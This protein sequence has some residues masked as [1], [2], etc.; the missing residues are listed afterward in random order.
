MDEPTIRFPVTCPDC[1]KEALF[2]RSL[3]SIASTL[4]THNEPLE[5]TTSCHGRHWIASADELQQI[6][7]YLGASLVAA[8]NL[9]DGRDARSRD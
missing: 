4:M 6:R 7:E 5:L 8:I 9:L 3:G 2:A 1:G